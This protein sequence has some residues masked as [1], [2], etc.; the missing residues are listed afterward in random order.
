MVF[1]LDFTVVVRSGGPIDSLEGK[2][3]FGLDFTVVVRSGGPIDSSEGKKE[4]R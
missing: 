2:M 4:G 3:V 1:G